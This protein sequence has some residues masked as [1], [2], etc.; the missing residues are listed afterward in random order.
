MI[1]E[2][3]G[4]YRITRKLGEGG[5]G[6]VYE[7]EHVMIGRRAAIK[8]LL[9]E[10]TKNDEACQRFFLEARAAAKTN[11]PGL[12][13]IFEFGKTDSGSAYMIMEFLDG[14]DLGTKLRREGRI[15]LGLALSITREVCG[16][17]AA[18][19]Q[20]GIVHRDL[21]PDNLFLVQ[22]PVQPGSFRVKVLDFGIAKLTGPENKDLSV[23]TRTG[24]VLGTPSYM[25]PEQCRGHGKIDWRSD[26]YSMGC[27]VYEMLTGH[28]PFRGS[29]YG[30]V[31]AQ[32]IYEPPPPLR[33]LDPTIP[34]VIEQALLRTLVKNPEQRMQTMD[35]L[36]Q[37]LE[38]YLTT[39]MVGAAPSG[40]YGMSGYISGVGPLPGPPPGSH[41]PLPGAMQPPPGPPEPPR[42]TT[43]RGTASEVVQQPPGAKKKGKG[44][45]MALVTAGAVAA[46]VATS[47]GSP[48]PVALVGTSPNPPAP[49]PDPAPAVNV[50]VPVP[51]PAP[52]PAPAESTE[53]NP[54]PT[55]APEPP[56]KVKISLTSTP[57]GAAVFLDGKQVGTTPFETELDKADG[58]LAYILKHDG[59]EDARLVIP[60]A[61]G[62]TRSIT[63]TALPPPP[64]PEPEPEPAPTPAAVEAAPAPSK[65]APS[66]P[67]P[68]KPSSPRKTTKPVKDGV[69]NPFK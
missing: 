65:P 28:P 8:C 1:G 17:L 11:H 31:L 68:S 44:M 69:V 60:A 59:H 27:I 45:V 12:T 35:E 18:V 34:E 57:A 19:H 64:K 56:A 51:E 62:G 67:A 36:G 13:E 33:T 24:S 49:A 7:A 9:P 63:L 3:L 55:P 16:A 46:V 58:N 53:P 39:G 2:T 41:T 29:G 21:K 54:T 14:E 43:M 40:G 42:T 22:N 61:E 20:K 4:G 66:K 10:L 52:T 50:P 15:S 23:K 25:S 47:S 30:E 48:E 37:I 32:H 5:M 6:A 26:I 38:M